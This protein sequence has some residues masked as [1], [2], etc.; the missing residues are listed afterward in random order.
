VAA[1]SVRAALV[2]MVYD[3]VLLL[4]TEVLSEPLKDCRTSRDG[5]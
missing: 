3:F 1:S 2:A 4:V 5:Y